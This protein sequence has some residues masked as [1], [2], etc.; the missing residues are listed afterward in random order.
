MPLPISQKS[1]LEINR[2]IG[3]KEGEANVLCNL[4][5][6]YRLKGDLDKATE[7]LESAL[8][9]DRVI[10]NKEGEA[11]DIVNLGAVYEIRGKKEE[12]L[13]YYEDALKIFTEIGAQRQIELIQQAIKRLKGE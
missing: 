6:T 10:G 3:Y 4:G 12:A 5:L 1:S 11:K 8:K 9:I 7:Y 2:E 13:K